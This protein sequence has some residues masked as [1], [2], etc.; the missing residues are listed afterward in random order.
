MAD[1]AFRSVLR[2]LRR[3]AG[4][5]PGGNEDQQLLEDFLGRRDEAAFEALLRRH[6]PMVLGVCRRLLHDPHDSEDAFQATFLVLLRKAASL[7]RR[8][9]LA[10]WLYGVACR[11][12]LKARGNKA[13]RQARERPAAEE[14]AAAPTADAAV[15]A[16]LRAVL[17]EELKR[18]P[19]RYRLPVVL[20]YLEGVTFAEAARQLGWPAGTVSGRLSRARELL[21]T[22]LTRRGVTLAPAAVGAVLAQ[23]AAAVPAPLALATLRAALSL[24][25]VAGGGIS[26]AVT[27]LTEGVLQAMFLTKVKIA[28]VILLAV[29]GTGAGTWGV[30]HARLAGEQSPQA[31]EAPPPAAEPGPKPKANPPAPPAAE[32]DPDNFWPMDEAKV[33]ALLEAS[34]A[35]KKLKELLKERLTTAHEEALGRYQQF[36]A[37]RGTMDALLGASLRLLDAEK[38]LSDKKDDQVAALQR[39]LRRMKEMEKILEAMFQAGR[40]SQADYAQA[41]SYRLQ[42]EIWLEK[43]KEKEKRVGVRPPGRLARLDTPAAL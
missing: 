19:A 8:D 3:A 15:G 39:H 14:P 13:R 35:G 38:E 9:V 33:K 22:R 36:L 18:L 41:K 2:T 21:R 29:G 5:P 24:T 31:A 30:A 25:V 16:E 28:V 6:G 1:N 42:A 7:R 12:A 10:G 27:T 23:E 40:A 11:T 20:C 26:P 17:D 37:G 43:A 32:E 34:T 4:P